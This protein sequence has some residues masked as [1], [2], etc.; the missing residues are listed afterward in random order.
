MLDNI[1]QCEN[2]S[3]HFSSFKIIWKSCCLLVAPAEQLESTVSLKKEAK[4]ST[5][6]ASMN[7][8]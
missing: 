6:S 5:C 2:L 4:Y 7:Q 1:M 3:V 8:I